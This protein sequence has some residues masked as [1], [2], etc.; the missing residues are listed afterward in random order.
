[1]DRTR[2]DIMPSLLASL[3]LLPAEITIPGSRRDWEQRRRAT[4]TGMEQ[5]M[6]PL[7]PPDRSPLGISRLESV[8]TPGFTRTRLTY[9][10]EPDD[11]VPAWLL[12]PKGLRRPAPG[13]L[14]LHQTTRIGKDEPVGLGGLPNLHYARELADRGYVCIVPDY[15]YL[16]ENRFDPYQRGYLSCTMKGIVNHRRAVDLLASLP[17]VDRRRIGV[18]G[19]SLGGHNALFVAAFDERLRAVV[20]SCGF[21]SFPKYKNGNLTGWDGYRYMPLVATR[22]QKDPARMP[23]DFPALLTALAPRGLFINAPLG[24]D[25]FDHSG[26][27]DCVEAARPVYEKTFRAGNRLIARYPDA[28]H[29]FPT[30]IREEVYLALDRW[31]R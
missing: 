17:E 28:G 11:P 3:I 4:L 13:M 2:R 18:I 19:H 1:M 9:L 29:D 6:G 8:E 21:T 31:L 12:I 10:G 24:D 16:G 15:P 27:R 30:P 23:F 5:L 7:P 22:Y 14:C 26:V 20:T 25:N